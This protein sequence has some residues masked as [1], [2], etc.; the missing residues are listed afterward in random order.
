MNPQKKYRSIISKKS[1]LCRIVLL[2]LYY[3]Y[4]FTEFNLLQSIKLYLY[5]TFRTVYCFKDNKL[6][7][8]KINSKQLETN[9]HQ[10]ITNVMIKNVI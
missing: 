6:I 5:G 9:A 1:T 2:V 3:S 8:D 4:L 7:I 10:K